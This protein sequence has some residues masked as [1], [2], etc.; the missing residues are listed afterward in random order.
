M[1]GDAHPIGIVGRHRIA[2]VDVQVPEVE[3]GFCPVYRIVAVDRLL[4]GLLGTVQVA[5][6][7]PQP[8]EDEGGMGTSVRGV[9]PVPL[10]GLEG[11]GIRATGGSG[12]GAAGGGAPGGAGVETF[13]PA[14]VGHL[15]LVIALRQQVFVL[16]PPVAF[17]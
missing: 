16:P 11:V 17:V 8:T 9:E 10:L 7:L 5:P 14:G 4:I 15:D 3:Q 1:P 6:L 13:Q 12:C 2:A